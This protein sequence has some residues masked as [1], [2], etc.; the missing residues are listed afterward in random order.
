MTNCRQ[1]AYL[2]RMVEIFNILN[3]TDIKLD[4]I[5]RLDAMV[6]LH[7]SDNAA[8]LFPPG[9]HASGELSFIG[10]QVIPACNMQ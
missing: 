5:S 7:V 4:L 3:L 8:T 1:L 9:L 2:P 10:I 6:F